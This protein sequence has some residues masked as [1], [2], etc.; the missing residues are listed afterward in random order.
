MTND[1]SAELPTAVIAR[2]AE[3]EGLVAVT[4]PVTPSDTLR[5]GVAEPRTR[6]AG[7]IWGLVLI[8]MAGFGIWFS[9]SSGFDLLAPWV[10]SLTPFTVGIYIVLVIAAFAVIT[11]LVVLI[12]HAQKTFAARRARL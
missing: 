11:A 2:E 4:A 5:L 3:A 10:M 12:R 6:W 8:A 1:A 9:M 7:I